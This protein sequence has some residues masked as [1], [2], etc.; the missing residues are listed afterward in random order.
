MQ[1]TKKD[2]PKSQLELTV[3]L[4]L[5]EFGPYIE[6]G[7]QKVSE[8]VKIEGFRPG[9]VPT[10]ILKQKIGEM[11]IL[12]EAANIAV[13]KTI[14]DAIVQNTGDR[15]A[16]GQPQVN[17]TK[18]APGNAF[19][20]KIT[21]SILPEITLGKYKDLGI[22]AEEPVVTDEDLDKVLLEL[23]EI[24]AHEVAVDRPVADKDKVVTDVKI[25]LDKVP[26]ENGQHQDLMIMLGKEYFVPGFDKKIIG[27]KKGETKEFTLEYPKEHHQKNLAGK[28]VEFQVT[29]KEVFSR[30]LHEM[31]DEFASHFGL[32]TLDELKKAFKDNLLHEKKKK[33]DSKFEAEMLEKI[34]K[35]SKFSDVPDILVDSEAKNMVGEL[36]QSI[37]RQGGKFEDY[38]QHIKKDYNS[39][40]LDFAPNAVKRVKS[41]LVIREIAKAEKME[42]SDEEIKI[43][44][45]ALR[46]QY[47]S[48]KD[49]LKMFDE[50]GYDSYLRNVLSNEKVINQLKEWNYVRPGSK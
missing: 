33:A 9:K 5:E 17:I 45:E 18:L 14:D 31:N 43:K 8:Q 23:R 44:K 35:D 7:A 39:L 29:V 38:L 22:K 3:E 36:E 21:V 16:V 34:I 28:N 6:K 4:S 48:N 46:V 40:M 25:F 13:R 49:V 12:E 2:L 27:A 32:K 47:A 26:V 20:Y 24:R 1:V 37:V 15:Q 50:P 41:A 42:V 19:E 10:D 30:E 11:T